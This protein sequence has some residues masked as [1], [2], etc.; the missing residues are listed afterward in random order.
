[1]SRL[2]AIIPNYNHG[3]YLPRAIRALADQRPAADEILVIDD[4]S[5]DDSIAVLRSFAEG[6]PTLR[7][8]RNS[9]N[10]GPILTLNRGIAEARGDYIYLGAADD[11]AL[12]GLF[13]T[14]LKLLELHPDAAFAC[15]ECRLVSDTGADLGIRPPARPLGVAGH[16]AAAM[17]PRLLRKSDN[18]ALTS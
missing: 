9:Q 14:G 13:S 4:G 2:T 12:P 15:A 16:V 17:V 11:I 18:W 10:C 5:S 7:I 3:R 1:M 6:V 8:I